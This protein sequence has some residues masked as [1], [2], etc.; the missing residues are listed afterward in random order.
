MAGPVLMNSSNPRR[1]EYIILNVH[2]DSWNDTFY[3]MN[4]LS[5]AGSNTHCTQNQ[6]IKKKH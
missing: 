3:G 6:Q 4:A 1:A 5:D 2:E